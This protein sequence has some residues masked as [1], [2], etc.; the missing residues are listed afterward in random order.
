MA[1]TPLRLTRHGKEGLNLKVAQFAG[2]LAAG[3]T[4]GLL[5]W[6][7]SKVCS[8]SVDIGGAHLTDLGAWMA[9]A[10]MFIGAIAALFGVYMLTASDMA[11][12]QTYIFAIVCG[13]AWQP[14]ITAAQQLVVN[15]TVTDQNSQVTDQ[16]QQIQAANTSGNQQQIAT[17]AQNTT[18][19]V[20]NA[21]RL[22][23]SVSDPQK[24][25]EIENN[26]GK[27]ISELQSSAAS[28]PT[29]SVDGLKK[30]SLTAAN[31]GESN[32]ALRAIQS[33]DTIGSKAATE[34]NQQVAHTVRDSLLEL[35]Q[36]SHDP[37]V[38]R[39]AQTAAMKFAQQR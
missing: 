5:Y 39:Q 22:S 18:Q 13:L 20:T 34:N 27:A 28:A 35:A 14:I 23:P 10:L 17:A 4:G 21:L 12:T 1:T 36:Q 26:S 32:V 6:V 9:P 29:A 15:K 3:A 37:Q 19:A 30:I 8:T 11:K 16:V 2:V 33:L 38:Q 25:T 24:K 7:L 31:S